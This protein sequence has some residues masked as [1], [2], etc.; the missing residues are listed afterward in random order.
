MIV[1]AL[2]MPTITKLFANQETDGRIKIDWSM[3]DDDFGDKERHLLSYQVFLHNNKNVTDGQMVQL[4]EPP[5]FIKPKIKSNHYFIGI[6][7][8][9]DHGYSETT[10]NRRKF[11]FFFKIK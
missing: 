2:P 11:N 5:A 8:Y 3:V 10:E 1:E 9:D 7:V 6:T 4:K